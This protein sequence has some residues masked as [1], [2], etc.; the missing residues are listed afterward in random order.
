MRILFL[1]FHVLIVYTYRVSQN[2]WYH[3]HEHFQGIALSTF[4]NSF[5]C[6]AG[7]EKNYAFSSLGQIVEKMRRSKYNLHEAIMNV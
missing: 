5:V 6:N 4:V 1:V 2:D 3:M 7:K